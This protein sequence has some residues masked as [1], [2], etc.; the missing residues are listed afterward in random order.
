MD[1]GTILVNDTGLPA[2]NRPVGIGSKE[3]PAL[4]MIYQLCRCFMRDG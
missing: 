2:E 4:D 3:V 1:W